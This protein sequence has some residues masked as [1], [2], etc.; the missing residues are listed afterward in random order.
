MIYLI[1]TN[2]ELQHTGKPRR[3]DPSAVEEAREKFRRYLEAKARELKP[4][5]IGEELFEFVIENRNARSIAKSVAEKLK[6]EH[7]FCDPSLDARQQ[8]GISGV[9]PEGVPP[10]K[11][12][13]EDKI[14]EYYWFICIKGCL[15]S[16]VMFVCGANH[17]S[18]FGKLLRFNGWETTVLHPYWGADIF[19]HPE[20]P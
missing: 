4:N 11:K 10:K 2:H 20:G 7:R 17:I 19:C 3:G 8:L 5:L 1:G 12:T 13:E 9:E 6:I 15:G 16:P 18:S 14:R